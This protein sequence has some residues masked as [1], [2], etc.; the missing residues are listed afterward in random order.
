MP[1]RLIGTDCWIFLKRLQDKTGEFR[2]YMFCQTKQ[3]GLICPRD[4]KSGKK[5]YELCASCF[6]NLSTEDFLNEVIYPS[7]MEVRTPPMDPTV[8][9]LI[10]QQNAELEAQKKRAKES[11]A[12]K[13]HV[14]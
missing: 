6:E 11:Q 3:R 9:D 5:P 12:A 13:T 1:T 10:T 4:V 8:G 7:M 14:H 2:T